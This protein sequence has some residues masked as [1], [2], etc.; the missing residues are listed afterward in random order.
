MTE[1]E[2]AGHLLKIARHESAHFTVAEAMGFTG[3]RISIHYQ[4]TDRY[5]GKSDHD[6]TERCN[7][8]IEVQ[9]YATRR[10]ITL[11][12]GAI[13]ESLDSDGQVDEK[14]AGRIFEGTG[15]GADSDRSTSH[16]FIHLIHHVT[17]PENLSPAE[18]KNRLWKLA[19]AVTLIH[20][21]VVDAIARALLATMER[22]PDGLHMELTHQQV[23]ILLEGKIPRIDTQLDAIS[24]QIETFRGTL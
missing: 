13:G 18:I 22:K 12:A 1:S 8:L 6:L 17:T 24:I 20:A 7:S 21:P 3:K 23:E 19:L 11:M 16:E 14:E 2:H 9:Q 15:T 5:H 10:T 4:D